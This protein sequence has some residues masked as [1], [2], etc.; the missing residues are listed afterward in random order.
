MP[1][2]FLVIGALGSVAY[3][4]LLTS[5]SAV[6]GVGIFKAHAY[7]AGKR[8]VVGEL[9]DEIARITPKR[10][11]GSVVVVAVLGV[12]ARMAQA[13]A[14]AVLLVWAVAA[15]AVGSA[16]GRAEGVQWDV[17]GLACTVAADVERNLG[18]R[19]G[20]DGPSPA[21]EVVVWV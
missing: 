2:R 3:P 21:V 6:R 7:A 20:C 13:L 11:V 19:R 8:I 16:G 15:S 17:S 1:A 10:E 12:G 4:L 9:V 14:V 5:A 18:G